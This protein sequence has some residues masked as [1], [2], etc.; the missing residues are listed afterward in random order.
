M[1]SGGLRDVVA[2]KSPAVGTFFH[3]VGT[4]FHGGDY[5]FHGIPVNAFAEHPFLGGS[6]KQ[7]CLTFAKQQ[8]MVV[9][10]TT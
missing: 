5:F 2:K 1:A 4:F 7:V 9:I 8:K 10:S 3:A 6:L